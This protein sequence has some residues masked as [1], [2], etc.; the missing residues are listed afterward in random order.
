ML[1]ALVLQ[2]AGLGQAS[3]ML[4]ITV[5][6]ISAYPLIKDMIKTVRHGGYGL[7][8]LALVAILVSLALGEY[9]TA[10]V[11]SLMLIG[12]E[13]LEKYAEGQA[14]REL[15][16]LV[17]RAPSMAHLLK[18]GQTKDVPVAAIKLGD[19]VLVKPGEIIP[20]DGTLLEGDTT[21][22]ESS[23][24]GESLPVAK[25]PGQTVLSGAVNLDAAITIK[26][27]HTSKDSQYQ[28]IIKLVREATTSKSPFVRLAD[29]Y[30]VPFTA[31]SFAIAGAAWVISGDMRRFLEVIVVATPCPLLIGAPIAIISGMSRAAKH[32]IIIKNGL[33]L[34][35][36]AAIKSIAFDKTGTLTKGS[37]VIDR[38]VAY[39]QRSDAELLALAA[40]IEHN[41]AH[42]LAQAV[43]TAAKQRKV[44]LAKVT[45]ITELPGSGLLAVWQGKQVL[46][47]KLSFM[48]QQDVKLPKD[49]LLD[50]T[51]QT[52]AFIAINK[53]LAGAFT[54]VD[55][56]RPESHN[57]INGLNDLGIKH[58]SMLTGDNQTVAN[59]I[60]G[61]LNIK[62]IHA[63]LM[64]ADKVKVLKNI[65]PEFRPSAMVGDGVNDAPVLAASDVGIALGAR[66]ATAASESADVVIMLDDVQRVVRAVSIA[67]HTIHIGMQSIIAGIA[68]SVGLMLIFSTGKFAPVLGAAVQELVDVVVILNALR[69]H[70]SVWQTSLKTKSALG[71]RRG[72]RVY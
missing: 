50:S 54:F 10:I 52:T 16:S 32:G 48:E 23:I 20:V 45:N 49:L 63:N 3:T 60:A 58:I 55:E 57:L 17:D 69:A 24:T 25:Q 66:G 7:D 12:G 2:L 39:D 28:Q 64:P 14:T 43:V 15:K 35:Q 56:L 36:L 42:I 34:E 21:I 38:I 5:S 6:L 65:P 53:Q 30:S 47:G 27:L 22:D 62:E 26:A 46:L 72:S 18:G 67:K 44:A 40:A 1:L 29:R 31:I 71:K 9:W 33:A 37:P 4:L 68:M 61:Q 11:I 13:A 41:S 59:H 70:G 51:S 19:I 8:V